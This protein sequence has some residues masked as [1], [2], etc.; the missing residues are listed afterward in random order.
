MVVKFNYTASCTLQENGKE[1]QTF[2]IVFNRENAML[3]S[4]KF[5][6][7][8]RNGLWAKA[9]KTV[10]SLSNNFMTKSILEGK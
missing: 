4:G 3:N 8:L 6:C 7:F 5:S 9:A 10:I 2:P 1:K